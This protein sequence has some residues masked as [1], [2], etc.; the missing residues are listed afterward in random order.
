MARVNTPPMYATKHEC[1]A[2]M[3]ITEDAIGRKRKR[4]PVCDGVAQI[5][6]QLAPE[7]RA[8][9]QAGSAPSV[10]PICF[11]RNRAIVLPLSPAERCTS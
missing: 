4:C 2:K 6:S 5:P 7:H 11:E 9:P 3:V 1:G 8:R 10:K